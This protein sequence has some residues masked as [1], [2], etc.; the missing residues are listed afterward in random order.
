MKYLRSVI[1]QLYFSILQKVSI[2]EIDE[3]IHYLKQSLKRKAA[4][5]IKSEQS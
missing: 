2:A 1:Q 4:M 5:M 3:R